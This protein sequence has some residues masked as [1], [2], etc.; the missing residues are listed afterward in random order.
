MS[1]IQLTDDEKRC[2]QFWFRQAIVKLEQQEVC[3]RLLAEHGQ[4]PRPRA[5]A[6][7][8]GRRTR[9]GASV[10]THELV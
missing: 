4:E 10:R 7:V 8:A 2:L 3:A 1:E 9:R 5:H 6:N